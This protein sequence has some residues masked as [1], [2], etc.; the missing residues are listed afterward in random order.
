MAMIRALIASLGG[1]VGFGLRHW[2]ALVLLVLVGGV[3]LVITTLLAERNAARQEAAREA[4]TIATQRE[5]IDRLEQSVAQLQH[6]IEQQNAAVQ[7]VSEESLQR[8]QA[9]NV[10]M[11]QAQ[12]SSVALQTEIA[13]L[14]ARN[15][16]AAVVKE[17][18]CDDALR[19]WR[20]GR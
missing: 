5:Q 4:Q 3:A 11:E 14:K 16:A 2:K 20:A 8:Q 15:Q 1:G 10:A 6:A 9:A 13:R 19:E 7:Q 18:S 12:R 17:K